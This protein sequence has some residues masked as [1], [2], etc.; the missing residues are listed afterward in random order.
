MP[1]RGEKEKLSPYVARCVAARQ[2]E[3]PGE[4]VKQS[5]AICYSMGRKRWKPK[6]EKA[7]ETL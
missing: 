7:R 2:K 1:V 4:D 3:H 6:N 5:V